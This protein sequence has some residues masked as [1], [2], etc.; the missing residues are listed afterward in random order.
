[1]HPN[2][3]IA[4]QPTIIDQL[5]QWWLED[6]RI[7]EVQAGW[8]G[9]P[10]LVGSTPAELLQRR[11]E[12]GEAILAGLV[13]VAADDDLAALFAVMMLL[14]AAKGLMS[15][16]GCPGGDYDELSAE[17]IALLFEKIRTYPYHRRHGTVAGNITAD[18]LK[19][20]LQR[21][22]RTDTQCMA[23]EATTTIGGDGRATVEFPPC[24]WTTFDYDWDAIPTGW[25]WCV[26]WGRGPGMFSVR[27]D[28]WGACGELLELLVDAVRDQ[29]VSMDDARLVAALRLGES[30]AEELAQRHG[31][32]AQSVRRRRQRVEATL[33]GSL[34]AA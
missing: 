5:Q 14:P 2:K 21:R 1:V 10:I 28:D 3:G 23:I 11:R 27:T 25:G 19:A 20:V 29:V 32:Q 6:R 17:I 33:K 9:Q 22:P 18:V 24:E 30:T 7:H 12:D 16:L 4:H 8:A 15:R 13:R 34:A 26:R 31:I